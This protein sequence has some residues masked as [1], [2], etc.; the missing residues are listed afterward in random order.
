MI[1]DFCA[2]YG[3]GPGMPGCYNADALLRLQKSAGVDLTVASDLGE[4]FGEAKS[5]RIPEGLLKFETAKPDIALA[6]L[7]QSIK[8]VRT[9]PTLQQWDFDGQAMADLLAFAKQQSFIVQVCLRLQDPR[10][11]PQ[12]APSGQIISALDKLIDSNKDVK[13][14]ISGANLGE[15]RGNTSPFMHENVW[16]DISHLQH[17]TNSLQKLME[18]LGSSNL[19]FASNSP[20]FYPY[21][22]VFRMLQAPISDEDRE[23][24]LSRNAK[25]LLDL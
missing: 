10:V 19:L 16:A 25:A 21:M 20:I 8:G 1:I 24:I 15:I 18:T 4:A 9:Y 13:F 23:R 11:M 5:D 22:A 12:A 6:S 17:P 14:V 3:C 7:G 2:H